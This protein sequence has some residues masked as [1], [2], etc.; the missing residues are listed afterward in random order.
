MCR[1]DTVGGAL[2]ARPPLPSDYQ[3]FGESGELF[4]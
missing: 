4:I 1:V 3:L 2:L